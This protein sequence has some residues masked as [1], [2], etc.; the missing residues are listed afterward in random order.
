MKLYWL[1]K[2]IGTAWEKGG[3]QRERD[4]R[5]NIAIFAFFREG[6]F[7]AVLALPSTDGRKANIR[8]A[9][10]TQ[11]IPGNENHTNFLNIGMQ[12][13]DNQVE[14]SELLIMQLMPSKLA[15]II[16]THRSDS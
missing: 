13:S 1:R 15:A 4:P 12:G 10:L 9:P 7:S 5:R 14:E 16:S 8:L 6:R 2:T 11:N 3:R